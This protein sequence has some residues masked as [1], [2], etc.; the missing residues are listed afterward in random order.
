[1]AQPLLIRASLLSPVDADH[2]V[3]YRD[4]GVL[5][6]EG[7]ILGVGAMSEFRQ[8]PVGAML[9]LDSLLVPGFVDVH[10]HWVQH[11]VRGRFQ[12][13]LMEWLRNHIWPEEMGFDNE[14]F[15]RR[16]AQNFFHDTVRAG[17][18]L[19]MAYSSPHVRALEI[20]ASEAIGDWVLGNSIMEKAAPEPLCRASPDNAD[21]VAPLLKKLG[22][23]HYAV[24]PR[25]ALNCSAAL[26]RDLGDLARRENALIQ[27]HLS[28]SV[29]EVREIRE[30][31]P[32][33]QDYTDVYDRAGL[34][35]PRSVLGHCIHLSTREH[36]TLARRGAWI[37]HCPSSNEALD[38]GRMDLQAI[39]R[40]GI[41]YALASDVGAG[42][43]HSM[44]HVMQRF[45]AQHRDAGV[46]VNAREALYHATL[47][48]AECLG[49]GDRAGSFAPGKRAD[50][51]ELPLPDGSGGPDHWFESLLAGEARDLEERP[52][53]TWIE[54]HPME[55]DFDDEDDDHWPPPDWD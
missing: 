26:M 30:A 6:H 24:T 39:R 32:E 14:L 51:V 17:T 37:A 36:Q 50:F 29:N 35:G 12:R 53:R 49:R 43:S 16:H 9:E 19:G 21:Q 5:V 27:T 41:R 44:L 11:H 28:E 55:T 48:G 47:A 4:G 2:W 31:F 1:M 46:D 52:L 25:F 15:A 13:D 8:Q 3:F 23:E 33:A 22:R 38:S 7:R 18:T 54:G 40:H 20:A 42:P 10:I 45:L 34:L